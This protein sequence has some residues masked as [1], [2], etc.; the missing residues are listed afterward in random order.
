MDNF[1]NNDL[2][3]YE[4]QPNHEINSR[5]GRSR[6]RDNNHRRSRYDDTEFSA[7]F[8][9]NDITSGDSTTGALIAGVVGL[10]AAIVALFTYPLVLGIVGIALGCYTV[11]KGS[12]I[13][14][15]LTIGIGVLA[16]VMPLFYTGPFISIF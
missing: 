15:F 14:G 5:Y 9:T 6:D 2:N 10:V 1:D 4:R 13:L 11:A 8:L 12:K 16:T 3:N 7:D